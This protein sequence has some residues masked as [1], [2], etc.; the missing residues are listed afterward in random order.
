MYRPSALWDTSIFDFRHQ[1]AEGPNK[2]EW[3]EHD[4]ANVA[5]AQTWLTTG[6]PRSGL[7]LAGYEP[8]GDRW[9]ADS[10][11]VVDINT[12]QLDGHP[13]SQLRSRLP[14]NGG[15]KQRVCLRPRG[16]AVTGFGDLRITDVIG[17]SP[18]ARA[19]GRHVFTGLWSHEQAESES[20]SWLGR[21]TVPDDAFL[22]YWMPWDPDIF[23]RS[24]GTVNYLGPSL[25]DRTSPAGAHL[26]NLTTVQ[27]VHSGNLRYF[28]G[29]AWV[30]HALGVDNNANAA[31]ERTPARSSGATISSRR[32]SSGRATC[33]TIWSCR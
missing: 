5:L 4:I 3:S 14:A 22:P 9:S 13:E 28:D 32:R 26:P 18:L 8:R 11:L 12:H 27:P 16:D 20:Y 24:F 2:R 17:D 25:L 21:T 19:L 7:R 31:R 6:R 15:N 23:N 10:P 29:N 30:D 33:S 1:L